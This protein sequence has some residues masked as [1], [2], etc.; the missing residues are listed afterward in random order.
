MRIPMRGVLIWAAGAMLVVCQS[1]G[2]AQQKGNTGLVEGQS[3]LANAPG[4]SGCP[5]P[6]KEFYPCASAKAKAFSP[7]RTPDGKPDFQGY[8]SRS[9]NLGTTSL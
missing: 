3:N 5:D 1:Q 9:N 7:R 4:T 2:G 6:L 8:W